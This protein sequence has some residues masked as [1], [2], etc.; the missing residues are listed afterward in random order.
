MDSLPQEIYD[1]IAYYFQTR[2]Q[3]DL[4]RDLAPEVA[5]LPS[6]NGNGRRCHPPD[7]TW[8]KPRLATLSRR[9]QATI[10]KQTFREIKVR[11]DDLATFEA[12]VA[13]H[14]RALVHRL[15]YS[16]VLPPYSRVARGRFESAQDRLANDRVFTTA[17]RDLFQI[18]SSWDGR[19]A[20][21]GSGHPVEFV[22]QNI[23]SPS[24]DGYRSHGNVTNWYKGYFEGSRPLIRQVRPDNEDEILKRD[25]SNC[26]FQYS[27]LNLAS[28]ANLPTVPIITSFKKHGIFRQVSPESFIRISACFPNMAEAISMMW[29]G[30]RQ[31]PALR[32]LN[33]SAMAQTLQE[34]KLPSSLRSLTL[35]LRQDMIWNHSWTPAD[36]RPPGQDVDLLCASLRNATLGCESLERL[37]IHGTLDESL[38]WPGI[39]AI[40]VK[41]FWQ[42]L[43]HLKVHFHMTT[44]TGEW[45]F[46][47]PDNAPLIEQPSPVPSSTQMPPGY[48]WSEEED[49]MA[50]LRYTDQNA[51][52]LRGISMPLG[53]YRDIYRYFVDNE[54]LS[55]L[56]KAF[57]KACAQ[58]PLLT[59]ASLTCQIIRPQKSASGGLSPRRTTWGIWFAVPGTAI[60]FESQELDEPEFR[61]CTSRR[62]VLKIHNWVPRWDLYQLLRDIGRERYGDRLIEK[63][64]SSANIY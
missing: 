2:S 44:P 1:E 21:H 56:V 38:F 12:I 13:P 8:D 27:Y 30:E 60:D 57:A 14:R 33:R 9:W 24:D 40:N 19:S 55:P 36:L 49:T 64:L 51:S 16:I 53:E 62:L 17:L 52:L 3:D 31:Y 42:N 39:T 35:W 50:A 48:G 32:S 25:L 46:R 15:K 18:L 34:V 37:S 26:R 59:D 5:N 54:R 29:D 41:P 58:M 22:L 47:F 11:S 6:G 63:R 10:E 45:Y 28:P 23:Y 61:L 43:K 4:D 20:T 7:L